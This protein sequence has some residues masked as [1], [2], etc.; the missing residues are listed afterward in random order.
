M[1][2]V[3]ENGIDELNTQL[4]ASPKIYKAAKSEALRRTGANT[5]KDLIAFIK[6]TDK[7]IHKVT[8]MVKVVGGR[9]NITKPHQIL[10]KLARYRSSD[11]VLHIDFGSK[12]RG[13]PGRKDAR[14]SSLVAKIQEGRRMQ[15]TPKM[16]RYFAARY[17]IPIK[18]GLTQIVTEK[19][20]I[21][22]PFFRV[23]KRLMMQ[24]YE[25]KFDE[26]LTRRLEEQQ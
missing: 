17:G 12:K 6:T 4:N 21:V 20:E 11:T 16:R 9:R 19:R 15:V 2:Q 7:R 1:I 18:K 26:A 24:R 13:K 5:R 10:T 25:N 23:N 22:T 14:I 3:K 8:K